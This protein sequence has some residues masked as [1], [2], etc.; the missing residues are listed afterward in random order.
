MITVRAKCRANADDAFRHT[1]SHLD[2]Y[3]YHG[4][5]TVIDHRGLAKYDVVLTSYETVRSDASRSRNLQSVFWFRVVLDEGII[6]AFIFPH[7]HST[8]LFFL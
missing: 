8:D 6:Q 2:V 3:L 7:R 4:Q 5:Q 1:A